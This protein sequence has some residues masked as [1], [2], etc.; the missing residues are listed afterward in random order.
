MSDSYSLY[1]YFAS[2][3]GVF[4]KWVIFIKIRANEKKS[5]APHTKSKVNLN[6]ISQNE[7][8]K[9]NLIH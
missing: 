6:E 7:I 3:Q 8:L 4:K 1:I 2:N 9:F 5:E